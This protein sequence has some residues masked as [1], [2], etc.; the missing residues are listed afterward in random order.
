MTGRTDARAQNAGPPV[1]SE[2]WLTIHRP[3]SA[4]RAGAVKLCAFLLPLA[5][6][7]VVSY[8]P[9]VW[10]PMVKVQDAGDSTYP[11]GM[12]VEREAFEK[13]KARLALEGKA[14]P[15]GT[16]S[17]PVFL[18]APHEVGTALYAAFTTPPK[19]RKELWLHESLW[20]TVK[21][22]LRGFALAAVLAVPL[23]LV[24]GT[25]DLFS[26]LFEPFLDFV[27]YMPPP[28]FGALMVAVLG[29]GEGPKVSII[30]IGTF[31][32]LALIV[33]NT[34]RGVDGALLE[35]AQTLGASRRRLMMRVVLPAVLPGIYTDLRVM[36]GTAWVYVTIAE[37]I[38]AAS[39]ISWFINQQ[40]KYRRYDNV[41]AGIFVIGMIGLLTDQ[42]LLLLGKYLFPWRPGAATSR[43]L[44]GT[45]L[46]MAGRLPGRAARVVRKACAATVG[47]VVNGLC[48]RGGCPNRTEAIQSKSVRP[49][50]EAASDVRSA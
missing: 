45:A 12:L 18:P 30:F 28:A 20:Q 27:R 34:A 2:A 24:C 8:M 35:A 37:L 50:L 23:G 25:F 39:G 11:V 49:E 44:I 4:S 22:V 19:F 13:D 47:P 7:C 1:A 9:F 29:I 21:V 46:A 33:A 17:N 32:P 26:K 10:H 5:L 43:G 15:A 31:F 3:L 48:A 40:G 36:L 16:P 42:L 41:F 38:G 14:P 6:W